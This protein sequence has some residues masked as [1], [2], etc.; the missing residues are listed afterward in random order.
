MLQTLCAAQRWV[1]LAVQRHVAG[2]PSEDDED[3]SD[4]QYYDTSISYMGNGSF[5]NFNTPYLKFKIQFQ[6]GIDSV[7]T[8]IQFNH[9]RNKR[10]WDQKIIIK[11]KFISDQ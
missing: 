2:G 1:A 9:N 5:S 7:C 3:E 11:Q 6:N 4:Y 8:I 10:V